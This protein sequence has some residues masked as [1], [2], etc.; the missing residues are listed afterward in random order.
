M[1]AATPGRDIRL[2]ESGK[3]VSRYENEN[4]EK[5]IFSVSKCMSKRAF[6]VGWSNGDVE[7]LNY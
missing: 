2:F 6:A 5:K 3:C 4:Q 7:I 1:V